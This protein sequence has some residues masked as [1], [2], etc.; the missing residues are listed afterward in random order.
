MGELL[1][2]QH[3]CSF[4]RPLYLTCSWT[5]EYWTKPTAWRSEAGA[6]GGGLPRRA[7]HVALL[8][9]PASSG[10]RFAESYIGLVSA[11]SPL[12]QKE[13]SEG[14]GAVEVTAFMTRLAVNDL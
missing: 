3:F 6:V 14:P 8:T 7:A 5:R 11:L 4:C 2:I 13:T 12:A 9:R 10:A 1:Y